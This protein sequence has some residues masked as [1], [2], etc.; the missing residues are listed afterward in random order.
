MSPNLMK[1]AATASLLLIGAAL[2]VPVQGQQSNEDL[3][4]KAQNPIANLISVP[5]FLLSK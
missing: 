1:K 5:L 4:K 3:A 2:T